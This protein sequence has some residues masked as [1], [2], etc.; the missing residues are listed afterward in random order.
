[1][2]PSGPLGSLPG[3]QKPGQFSQANKLSEM[4]SMKAASKEIMAMAA[5]LD[6]AQVDTGPTKNYYEEEKSD[7]FNSGEKVG[8]LF[9]SKATKLKRGKRD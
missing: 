1:V 7:P 5:K 9:S 2:D 6:E 4:D 3:L 8:G